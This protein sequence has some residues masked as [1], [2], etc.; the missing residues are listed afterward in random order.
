[1][2]KIESALKPDI[3]RNRMPPPGMTQ[4][5][6]AELF[7]QVHEMNAGKSSVALNLKTEAGRGLF[8][9]LISRA[10]VFAENFAPG[11]L[12]RIG[13]SHQHMLDCNS[14]LVILSQS[15]YGSE[16]PLSG[17]RA[18]APIMTALSG[19]ESLI[20]YEGGEVVP[21]ICSSNGDL[22]AAYYGITLILAALYNRE[23]TGRGVCIDMSQIEACTCMA[24]VAMAE[25]GLTGIVPVP[26]GNQR[27]DC[28]PHGHYPAVGKD[29][30]IALAIWSDDEWQTLCRAL[31]CDERDRDRFASLG[32]RLEDRKTVDDVISART[33]REERDSLFRRLQAFGLCCTP[34]LE[35]S[36]VDELPEFRERPLWAPVHHH[37]VGE[38]RITRM[39]WHFSELDQAPRKAAERMGESTQAVMED[40]LGHLP[41]QLDSWRQGAV[42]D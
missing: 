33:R 8:M 20:G 35:V 15:P 34:V 37:R 17:Q 2:L 6:T 38:M 12:E 40:M 28:A 16:G 13:L 42:F 32:A 21:Q 11:W 23:Q 5:E 22:V 41:E 26:S 14:R 31:G 29:R 36:E 19:T 27:S 7:P 10:D 39:P 4:A 18:Y 24:G 1:V 3:I 25:Y 9:E 30:W